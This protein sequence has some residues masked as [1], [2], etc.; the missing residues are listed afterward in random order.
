MEIKQHTLVQ[1]V[2]QG[3]NHRG[4]EKMHEAELKWKCNIPKLMENR[5]SS[6]Q[7]E[8]YSCK[9][10]TFIKKKKI[11]SQVNNLTLHLKRARRAN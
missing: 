1:P 11:G 9:M 6:T 2:G 5:G 10:L 8:M 7:K 4:N 3:R